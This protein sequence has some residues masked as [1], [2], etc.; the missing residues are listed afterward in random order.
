MT[1]IKQISVHPCSSVADFPTA[2]CRACLRTRGW[3]RSVCCAPSARESPCEYSGS[4]STPALRTT[5]SSR[6][7]DCDAPHERRSLSRKHTAQVQRSDSESFQRAAPKRYPLAFAGTQQSSTSTDCRSE[8]DPASTP[9]SARRMTHRARSPR[10][11]M[12]EIRSEVSPASLHPTRL[13]GGSRP[14]PHVCSLCPG[15]LKR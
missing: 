9:C 10:E 5:T 8:D 6:F 14:F 4:G 12:S 3:R 1:R 13:Q 7:H 15:D 11:K 2:L